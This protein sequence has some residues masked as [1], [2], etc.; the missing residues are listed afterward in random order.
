MKKII[1]FLVGHKWTRFFPSMYNAKYDTRHCERCH[2]REQGR[3]V[4]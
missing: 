3:V 4:G 1:C 2:K